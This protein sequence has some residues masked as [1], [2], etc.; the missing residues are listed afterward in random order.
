MSRRIIATLIAALLV[1]L[2]SQAIAAEQTRFRDWQLVTSEATCL[3]LNRVVSRKSG[4]TV[5][6]VI[7]RQRLDGK[8]GATIGVR[9]PNGASIRDAIAYAHPDGSPRAI[10]L[11]W[12]SCSSDMCLAAGD[13]SDQA[14][15][16][17]KRGN[18]IIVGF[19]PLPDSRKLNVTVSLSGMTR[20]W[21][22]L[23]TCN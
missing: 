23:Q 4:I 1:C 12:Q 20:G 5:M 8:S 6:E 21:Q 11:E 17:L 2:T 3:L 22:F 15:V 13:L 16:D 10:G 14:L 7:L 19:T 18:S 9:V